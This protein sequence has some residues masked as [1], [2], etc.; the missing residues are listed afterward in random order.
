MGSREVRRQ[1][2]ALTT[3]L[4]R[5]LKAY[6]QEVQGVLLYGSLVYGLPGSQGAITFLVLSQSK[7]VLTTAI[8]EM[9]EEVDKGFGFRTMLVPLVMRP[10]EVRHALLAGDP[11]LVQVFARGK[12]LY[13]DGTVAALRLALGKPQGA[14]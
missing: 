6:P 5:L 8:Q 11:F 7:D 9:A 12:V 4:R 1:E 13:D 10:L 14:A 2:R 3:L